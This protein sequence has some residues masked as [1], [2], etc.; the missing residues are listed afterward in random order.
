MPI[1]TADIHDAHPDEVAVC[2]A[3]FRS[4]GK[5]LEFAG[6][7]ATLKCH[8]DHMR[9]RA[10]C[11]EPGEGRVLVIDAGGSLRIGIMGDVMA[12]LAAKN[13]WVGAVIYGAVRDTAG[14][15]EL[16]FGVKALGTTARRND[17]DMGGVVDKPVTIGGVTFRP[18]DWV[19]ADRDA[20]I[21]SAHRFSDVEI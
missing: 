8:E 12:G 1:V 17:T 4:F 21:V 3:Q 7:C 2:E 19:Y 15:D 9:A 13:G 6:P 20:V 14:I 5:R 18:G 10:L 16:D 11:N